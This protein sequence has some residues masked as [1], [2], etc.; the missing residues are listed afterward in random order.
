MQETAAGFLVGAFKPGKI[1]QMINNIVCNDKI[2]VLS[3][4]PS[5][6]NKAWTPE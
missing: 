2:E 3:V 1:R 6:Q 4:K 5:R